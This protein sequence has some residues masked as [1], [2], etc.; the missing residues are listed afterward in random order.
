[1]ESH[2]SAEWVEE[3]DST[4]TDQPNMLP[5]AVQVVLTLLAPD[6]DD[7]ELLSERSYTATIPLLYAKPLAKQAMSTQ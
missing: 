5:R 7:P 2:S 1:M 6:P 4:G 3:W